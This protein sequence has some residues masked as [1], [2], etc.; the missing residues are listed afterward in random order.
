M[1]CKCNSYIFLSVIFSYLH[2]FSE[3]HLRL[4]ICFLLSYFAR[5]I[6]CCIVNDQAASIAYKL[7]S[8]SATAGTL[9][10]ARSGINE[11]FTCLELLSGCATV[12]YDFCNLNS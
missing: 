3:R 10:L 9:G 2:F 4:Y 11:P 1:F 7:L 12:R 8:G 6:R 5:Y